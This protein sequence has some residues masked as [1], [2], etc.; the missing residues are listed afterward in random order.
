VGD[1]GYHKDPITAQ[2]MTDAFRDAEALA[3]AVD[4][5]LSGLRPLADALADY[6]THRD[7]VVMPMYEMTY[8]LAALQP[9]PPEMQELM[10]ALRGNQSDTDRFLG[11]VAG[12]TPIAEFYAPENLERIVGAG[13]AVRA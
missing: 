4:A 10:R 5:G 1:A 8:Q 3:E 11:T 7:G 2:G 9:P 13:L 6:Q 12:T